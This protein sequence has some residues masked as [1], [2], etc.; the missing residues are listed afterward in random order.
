VFL[1]RHSPSTDERLEDI[2]RLAAEITTMPFAGI[3]YSENGRNYFDCH[4]TPEGDLKNFPV[5]APDEQRWQEQYIEIPD[6]AELPEEKK[7][8]EILHFKTIRHFISVPIHNETE[9]V[10]GVLFLLDTRPGIIPESRKDL[11]TILTRTAWIIISRDSGVKQLNRF[12]GY[13]RK[14]RNIHL[15]TD[16]ENDIMLLKKTLETCVEQFECKAGVITEKNGANS[17]ECILSAFPTSTLTESDGLLKT[18]NTY[19]ENGEINK[20][21]IP[22][23]GIIHAGQGNTILIQALSDSKK[24]L[25]GNLFLEKENGD[26]SDSEKMMLAP[27]IL[28]C[29]KHLMRIK[30]E[31]QRK[32]AEMELQKTNRLLKNSQ[33]IGKIGSW[34]FWLKSAEVNVSEEILR[35]FELSSLPQEE[36]IQALRNRME[37]TEMEHNQRIAIKLIAGGHPFSYRQRLVFENGQS[38]IVKIKGEP[39]KDDEGQTI[40][41][42][43]TCQDITEQRQIATDLR[44]FFD[45]SADLLCIATKD[46]KILKNSSS[47]LD[48]LG[49]SENELK[50]KNILDFV[51]PDEEASFIKLGKQL[52]AI[53]NLKNHS[54]LFLHKDGH[55]VNLEWTA[56]F[57]PDFNRIYA[58]AKDITGKV[59]MEELILQNKIESAKARAKDVFLANMSH[60]IRTPLNAIM[61]FN[62][63][64]ANSQ[65]SPQQRKNVEII[66]S[67][68]KTLNVIINDILDISKLESG[69]LELDKKPFRLE[70][71]CKQVIQLESAKAK[72]KGIKLFFSYDNEIP[73][74]VNGDEIR[75]NQIL[76][77]LI[78]NAIKFTEKGHVELKVREASRTEN[79][80]EIIF[81]VSDTG[82][83]V[84]KNKIRKIF[85]RFSQAESYT[86]RMYGGTGLG[87]SIV[88]SLIK[89]HKGKLSVKSEEGTGSVFSFSI[90]YEIPGEELAHTFLEETD[91]KI[92]DPKELKNLSLLLVDDNEHNQMLATS[93]LEK[94]GINLTTASN[95]KQALEMLEK[96]SVDLILMDLQMPLMDGITTTEKI[97]NSLGLSMPIIACS[98]HALP[99][100][101]RKCLESGMNDYISKPYS[102]QILI[103]SIRNFLPKKKDL[104]NNFQPEHSNGL[105]SHNGQFTSVAFKSN[106]ISKLEQ[107]VLKKL[108]DDIRII[109]DAMKSED[110]NSLEFKAHNLISSLSVLKLSEGIDL[111]RKLEN[112]IH[113]KHTE[114]SISAGEELMNY[115]KKINLNKS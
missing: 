49:Y 22:Q 52:L 71:I 38:K 75:L 39:V 86:T 3:S 96:K 28:A 74:I 11:L 8:S 34:E 66:Q 61:G 64:L 94:Y 48:L 4:L 16:L 30:S 44:R 81:S 80:A 62:E 9:E 46:G 43:G 12:E 68:S 76:L 37:T 70:K 55:A 7:P 114:E 88:K 13:F 29:T 73:E 18:L 92:T 45:L 79:H 40:L 90:C 104:L 2:A 60:E 51:H 31:K 5:L 101:K 36:L 107:S 27:L 47:F 85:R 1:K 33:S 56:A 82:I 32:K 26:F 20:A 67:A 95:G 6:L 59:E 25:I 99:S 109:S 63:I 110:W 19:S 72:A 106:S 15:E 42:Q 84:P 57:D 93:Y 41:V 83:G 50:G 87:L 100:E 91:N 58:S 69:K 103:D 77:N 112:A 14:I 54:N 24:G 65:L 105:G 53:G 98:A 10:I 23:T 35:I 17:I 89:L 111:S 21:S 108:P 97:R 113:E 78:S 115:L 102:E